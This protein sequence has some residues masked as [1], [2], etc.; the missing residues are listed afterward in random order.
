VWS[1]HIGH[2]L[3]IDADHVE[4]IVQQALETSRARMRES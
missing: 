1:I 3:G 2:R 4:S